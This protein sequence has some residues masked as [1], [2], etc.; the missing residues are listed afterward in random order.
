MNYLSFSPISSIFSISIYIIEIDIM[1]IDDNNYLSE[2]IDYLK[3]ME[4]PQNHLNGI[5]NKG[6]IHN[7][8]NTME[9]SFNNFDSLIKFL[10]YHYQGDRDMVNL[11]LENDLG[12]KIHES[13]YWEE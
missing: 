5:I 12:M 7:V 6:S 8:S 13:N 3:E 9:L 10:N 11:H 1:L 4:I 2:M